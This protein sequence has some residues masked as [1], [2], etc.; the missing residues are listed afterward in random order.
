MFVNYRTLKA[1]GNTSQDEQ[2]LNSRLNYNQRLFKNVL[3][4][5]TSYETNSGTLPQQDFTFVEVEPGQGNFT[6]IDY[7]D[8]GVQELGEFETAKFA[9]QGSY[10]RVLLP[11]QVFIQTHQNRF[12]QTVTFNPQQWN[13]SENFYVPFCNFRY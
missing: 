9:D 3:I 6:W 11:N 7:N 8:N 13:V 4:L 5:N 10:I 1:E 12:S 2:S